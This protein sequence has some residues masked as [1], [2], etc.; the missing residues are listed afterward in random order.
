MAS[1]YPE[2]FVVGLASCTGSFG[3][4]AMLVE[5]KTKLKSTMAESSLSSVFSNASSLSFFCIACV[6]LCLH[7]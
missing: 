7:V 4:Q 3:G 1:D 5:T 2:V 6:D